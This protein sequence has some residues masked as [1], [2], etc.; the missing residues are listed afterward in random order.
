MA[1]INSF[2]ILSEPA[3]NI[4]PLSLYIINLTFYV[5]VLVSSG[6]LRLYSISS[7][8][9]FAFETLNL[10]ALSTLNPA[11]RF[12]FNYNIEQFKIN[13]SLTKVTVLISH[14]NPNLYL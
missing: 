4:N 12:K 13:L 10:C 3:M 6:K 8:W 7:S 5:N 1:L 11:I 2:E 9:T 14:C